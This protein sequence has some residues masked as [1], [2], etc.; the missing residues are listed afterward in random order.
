M[1]TVTETKDGIRLETR[2]SYTEK[3]LDQMAPIG[4]QVEEDVPG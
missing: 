1:V 3:E 4:L 2:R